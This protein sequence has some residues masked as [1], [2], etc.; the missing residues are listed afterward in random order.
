MG[1]KGYAAISCRAG[2]L[3]IAASLV[4]FKPAHADDDTVIMG[5]ALFPLVH[6]PEKR[7]ACLRTA[8]R[9][10]LSG[11][12]EDHAHSGASRSCCLLSTMTH[13]QTA[14]P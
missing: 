12:R 3:L 1:P 4:A 5:I 11:V 7:P 10:K 9:K 2:L 14:Y 13:Q 8:G 6:V